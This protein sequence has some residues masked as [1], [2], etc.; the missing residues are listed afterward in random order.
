MMAALDRAGARPAQVAAF[1]WRL[2]GAH[3]PR[4]QKLLLAGWAAALLTPHAGWR[5]SLV[6]G[7]RSP[8]NRPPALRALARLVKGLRRPRA[9]AEAAACR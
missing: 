1:V 9:R 4:L 6:W 3:R 7:R 5:R 8:V 2:R